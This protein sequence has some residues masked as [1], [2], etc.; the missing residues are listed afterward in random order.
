MS[1]ALEVL[2]CDNHLLVLNKPAGLPT[3]PDDSGDAS[4]LDLGKAW[5]KTEY[6]KPGAV[7]LGVVH[8]LDR[9]VSGVLLFAR[10]SKAAER[11]SQQFRER[12][13]E[14]VYWG[15]VLETLEKT[16]GEIEHWL[17]KDRDRNRVHVVDEGREGAK[18]ARTSYR[19]LG[20][21]QGGTWLELR[22]HTG[23]SHQLRVACASLGSPLLGDLKYGAERPLSDK[24][25]ALHA[26]RLGIVHPTLKQPLT[27]EAKAPGLA[28]WR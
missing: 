25:I 1:A 17:W 12:E 2:H 20:Q 16:S 19:Y 7:F 27:F 22:P 10:T 5:I 13:T 3:V 26:R 11:L 4:L 21:K 9:P 6:N 15:L 28:C 18:F 8:R 14:K 23:R 24:S